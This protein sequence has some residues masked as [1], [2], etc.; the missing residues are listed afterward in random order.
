MQLLPFVGISGNMVTGH[1]VAQELN[2][3]YA[4]F[5]FVILTCS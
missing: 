2:L 3:V 5:I 1:N 4:K